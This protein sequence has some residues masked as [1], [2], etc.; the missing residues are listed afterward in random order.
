MAVKSTGVPLFDQAATEVAESGALSFP[1]AFATRCA[2][3]LY[4][5]FGLG[6]KRTHGE[7]VFAGFLI[8]LYELDFHFVA[9]LET[10]CLHVGEAI[11]GYFGYVE[12]SVAVG[13]EFHK[14]SEVE[15]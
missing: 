4:I 10:G 12:K 1:R 15:D 7:A 5:A 8:N 11:P 2:L 3:T 6:K 14:C 9:F 13:H